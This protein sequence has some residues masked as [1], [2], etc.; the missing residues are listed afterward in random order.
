QDMCN[1]LLRNKKSFLIV[2]GHLSESDLMER[3]VKKINSSMI[4]SSL[5][6]ANVGSLGGPFYGMGDFFITED[7]LI[8]DLGIKTIESSFIDVANM[9]PDK[10]SKLLKDEIKSDFSYFDINNLDSDIHLNSI[11]IGLAIR[12]WVEKN[13]LDAFTINFANLSL[14]SGFPTVPFLEASKSMARGIGYAGEGDVLT[15]GI[16]GALMKVYPETSFTEMFCPD[17]NENLILLS[18]M[19]ELNIS[20]TSGKPKLI[21]KSLPFI[22]IGDPAVAIGQFREGEAVLVNFSP[23]IDGYTLILSRVD[24]IDLKHDLKDSITGWI[25]PKVAI[26]DFLEEYSKSGGSH[27]CSIVYGNVYNELLDFGRIL[28]CKV[29]EI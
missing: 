26:D 19:G 4:Y 12:S 15:A 27:H 17:W 16:V 18:H 6:I 10:N 22:N 11:R 21:C 25:K 5:V 3:M 7:K 9:M 14:E 8:N 23:S 2:A 28:G 13:N 1:V 20:L 29:I 24:L